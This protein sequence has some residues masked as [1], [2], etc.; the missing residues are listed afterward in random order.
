MDNARNAPPGAIMMEVP[1]AFPSSGLK[2]VIVGLA[3]L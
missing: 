3:T 2:T 1:L